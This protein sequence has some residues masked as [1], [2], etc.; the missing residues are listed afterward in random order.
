M[1]T[2]HRVGVWAIALLL[3]GTAVVA[4]ATSSASGHRKPT[5]SPPASADVKRIKLPKKTIGIMGPVDAAEVIKLVND[6]TEK[7]AKTLGWKTIRVDPGG[8]PAKMAAG[9]TSLVNAHVN[10]I[11][12]T[13]MEP[14][15]IASGLRA[16][17]QAKIPVIDTH[18][19]TQSSKYFAGEYFLP[20]TKEFNLLL[21]RMKKGLPRGSKIATINLPQFLNAKIAGDLIKSA[22]PAAGWKIVANHDTALQNSV[23]DVQRAVG[24][25]IRANPEIDAIWGCC[26]F[27]P[28]GAIPA[29]R[30][31][32][33]DVKVYALHGIPSSISQAKTG[34]A[35]LEVSEYQKG[36]IIAIDELAAWFARKDP[37]AKRTPPQFAY[38]QQIVDSS[39]AA[40][41]YPYPTAKMLAPFKARWARLYQLP[42]K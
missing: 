30:A 6:A 4:V 14:A 40:A 20:P 13:T 9:M 22:A 31:S 34:I 7:A 38:K 28:T 10:A 25:M 35:V 1:L 41:G 27:A 24:D 17:A 2:G 21:A 12:L 32:G 36:G 18:T 37:I 5:G 8:D 23:A 29:I 39:N 26:D 15:T 42:A 16:A 11:V 33:K 3:V 19:K